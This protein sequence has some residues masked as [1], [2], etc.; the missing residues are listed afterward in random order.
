MDGDIIKIPRAEINDRKLM[1]K[2]IKSNLNSKTIQVVVS[3]KV[4]Y[5]K[6]ISISTHL[7]MQSYGRGRTTIP[8]KVLLVRWE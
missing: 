3:G 2:A 6:S 7:M 8:G 4:E 5:Q 1:G